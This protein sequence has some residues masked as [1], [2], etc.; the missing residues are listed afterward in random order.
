ML[1]KS[2]NINTQDDKNITPL[3]YVFRDGNL[4]ID[5]LLVSKGADINTKN[6]F[7]ETPLDCA[8]VI[9]VKFISL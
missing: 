5:K 1:T 9:L 4:E 7:D 6:E 3:H 8:L 2:A